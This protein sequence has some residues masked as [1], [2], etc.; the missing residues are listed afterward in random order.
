MGVLRKHKLD[1]ALIERL[2]ELGLTDREIAHAIG[3]PIGTFEG[4]IPRDE[5]LRKALEKG[6]QAPN[7]RVE[8]ALYRRALGYNVTEVIEEHGQVVKRV[9]KHLPPDVRAIEVWLR[10][11]I[12][13][14]WNIPQNFNLNLTMKDKAELVKKMSK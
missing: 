10:N 9:L 7:R 12:P 6:K 4:Y 11:R 5:K 3:V 14:R 2:A 13:E 8:Q 1:Y